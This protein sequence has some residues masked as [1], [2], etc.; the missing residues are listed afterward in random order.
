MSLP[1]VHPAVV[2]LLAV[3]AMAG[4]HLLPGNVVWLPWPW[5]LLG[6]GDVIGG[7]LW[8]AWLARRFARAGTPTR[9]GAEPQTLVSDGPFAFSRNPM[10]LGLLVVIGGVALLFGSLYP[11]AVWPL[12]ALYCDRVLVPG[13]ERRLEAHFGEAFRRYRERVPRWL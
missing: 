3:A 11:L 5:N 7:S 2:F 10:Y 1:R 6:L 9:P 4:L 8:N 12:C 13:E